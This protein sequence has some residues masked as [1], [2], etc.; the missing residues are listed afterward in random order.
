MSIF[1][2]VKKPAPIEPSPPPGDGG[3]REG[4]HPSPGPLAPNAPSTKTNGVHPLLAPRAPGTVSKPGLAPASASS[5][6]APRTNGISNGTA[7][8]PS[9]GVATRSVTPSSP[10]AGVSSAKPAAARDPASGPIDLVI[11]MALEASAAE[12]EPPAIPAPGT[13]TA[14]DQAAVRATFEDLA[15]P[16]MAEVRGLMMELQDGEAQASWFELARPLVRSLRKMADPVGH[17]AFAEALEKFDQAIG[18]LLAPGQPAIPS[19]AAREALMTAYGPLRAGLPAAFELEGERDRREPL[20]V[21]ALLEQVPGLEPV[22]IEAL[23][24]AGFGKLRALHAARA[25]EIAAVSGVGPEVA[26]AIAARVEAFRRTTP[27]GL[28]SVDQLA[29]LRNLERLRDVLRTQ[30]AAFDAV[31]RGWSEQDQSAKRQA[32]RE[33]QVTFLHVAIDLL[34]LGEIAFVQKLEKLPFTSKLDELTRFIGR[35][36]QTERGKHRSAPPPPTSA[37]TPTTRREEGIDR[38]G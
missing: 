10:P 28:A 9:N 33:R 26:A 7:P 1:T 3:R 8:R 18:E 36:L 16:Y 19:P 6:A 12:E 17:G 25:D 27:A 15:V 35:A 31:A 24:A 23:V 22:A 20:I 13:S 4:S 32:R 38:H 5:A 2:R 29:T 37:A 30:H 11:E 34:R 21:R 14:A